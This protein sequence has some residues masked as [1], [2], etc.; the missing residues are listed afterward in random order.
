MTFI[1]AARGV[2]ALLFALVTWLTVTPNPDDTKES[3]AIARWISAMLLGDTAY[4]DKVAHFMAYASLGGS[5]ALAQLRL[6][7]RPAYTVVAL[8]LYGIAL[9]GVQ[10]A[11][12]VRD[13]ELADAL[14]NAC[15]AIVGTLSGGLMLTLWRARA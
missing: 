4:S 11:M 3:L 12:G 14:A 15:G 7:G 2:F 9:E 13:P 10:G 6:A 5:A 1:N 8:A